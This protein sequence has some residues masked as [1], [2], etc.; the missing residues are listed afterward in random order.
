MF[1]LCSIRGLRLLA[2]VWSAVDWQSCIYFPDEMRAW[3]FIYFSF[4]FMLRL[5]RFTGYYVMLHDPASFAE[6]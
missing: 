4:P 3:I 5:M 1:F 2:L 6:R